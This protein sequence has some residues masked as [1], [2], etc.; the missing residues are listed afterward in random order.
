MV[1]VRSIVTSSDEQEYKNLYMFFNINGVSEIVYGYI[2]TF[3]HRGYNNTLCTMKELC[4]YCNLW[5]SLRFVEE[6]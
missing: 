5:S 2:S 6:S 4:Y 3:V 1:P